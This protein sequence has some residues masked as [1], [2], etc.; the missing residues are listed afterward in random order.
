MLPIGIVYDHEITQNM[1]CVMLL[2]FFKKPFLLACFVVIKYAVF[3]W[4]LGFSWLIQVHGYKYLQD[5][6]RLFS[7]CKPNKELT[8]IAL[9]CYNESEKELFNMKWLIGID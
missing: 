9:T 6:R 2:C 7:S 8:H 4:T 1:H 5:Y 3:M